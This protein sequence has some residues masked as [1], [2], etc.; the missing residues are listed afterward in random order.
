MATPQIPD[1]WMGT[2]KAQTFEFAKRTF[3]SGLFWQPLPGATARIR[4]AEV[5]KMAEEQDFDLVVLRTS[6]VPQAGFGAHADG[7]RPGML[8]VAA[9]V[10]KS[11]EVANRERSF[12]CALQV[13]GGKWLYVAQREGVLLHDGDML[14]NEATVR[15]RMMTDISLTEWQTIFA[16][17]SWGITDAIE[18][19]FEDLL[20]K[21][22]ANFSFKSWWEVRPV[23]N[24]L[25]DRLK[26]SWPLV[27]AV[28]LLGAGYYAYSYW[29][30]WQNEKA[31]AEIAE[32]EAALAAART[33]AVADHPWKK[34]ARAT[35][36]MA[37]CDTAIDQVSTFWPGNWT[38]KE[39]VCA[40][41]ALTVVW[42]ANEHGWLEHLQAVEPK[43]VPALDGRSAT[44][45]VPI[46]LKGGDNEALLNE[47]VR[48]LAMIGAAQRYGFNV[49][50]SDQS[51]T[52]MLPGQAP[53]A[54]S[55]KTLKW[56]VANGQLPPSVVIPALDGD[57][58]RVTQI[59]LAFTGGVMNWTMEGIQYVQP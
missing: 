5:E 53:A 25:L 39:A 55:W 2:P 51:A 14:G 37:A 8:S 52:P 57:G 7:V 11:L 27:A 36:F 59:K 16:P 1:D 44:L 28:V 33:N 32:Q 46:T 47:R 58:F 49:A 30:Q 4:K 42:T 45:A 40:N 56:T 17:K 43:A 12:L 9:L 34:Q 10:S 13:P 20:P 38:P 19:S 54:Q 29:Q 26:K 31:M 22:G 23:R 24:S 41:G 18:R 3:V 15:A 21:S 50:V 48:T 6:G 35:Q